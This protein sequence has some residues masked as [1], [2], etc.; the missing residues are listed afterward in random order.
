MKE[1]L[2]NLPN[3]PPETS[4]SQTTKQKAEHLDKRAV[5]QHQQSHNISAPAKVVYRNDDFS[6]RDTRVGGVD[7]NAHGNI[8]VGGSSNS[9]STSNSRRS[10]PVTAYDILQNNN[11]LYGMVKQ[12]DNEP[13]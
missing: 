4:S 5:A 13:R 1:L 9:G 3:Y 12:E 2:S 8:H 6:S 7:A 11:A 10:R